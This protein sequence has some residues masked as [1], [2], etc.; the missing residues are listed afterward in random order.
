MFGPSSDDVEPVTRVVRGLECE[1]EKPDEEIP[2]S[3]ELLTGF[4]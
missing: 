2:F 3:G 4:A 1:C